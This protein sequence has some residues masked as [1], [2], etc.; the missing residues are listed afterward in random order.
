MTACLVWTSKMASS[1]L[2]HCLDL[3]N[4]AAADQ[5]SLLL[6]T[7]LFHMANFL[8]T[9]WSQGCWTSYLVL[10]FL[11]VRIPRYPCGHC[12]TPRIL[13]TEAK[14]SYPAAFTI[15]CLSK[16]SHRSSLDSRGRRR[17]KSVNTKRYGSLGAIFG[18]SISQ[19]RKDEQYSHPIF[20]GRLFNRLLNKGLP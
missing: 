15:F 10:A 2:C 14:K 1:L 19:M 9:W 7:L 18:A 3:A 6:S 11:R 12:K 5:A 17:H 16:V 13:L 4:T 20:K 8:T